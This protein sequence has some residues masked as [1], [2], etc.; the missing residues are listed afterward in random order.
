MGSGFRVWALG[1]G[2][3]G[4]MLWPYKVVQGH[5][6]W[7]GI[8]SFHEL[9]LKMIYFLNVLGLNRRVGIFL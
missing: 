7:K 8:L 6:W 2:C 9:N 4:S 1:F 5:V 3:Q